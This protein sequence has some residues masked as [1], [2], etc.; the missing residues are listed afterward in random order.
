[1]HQCYTK[2]WAIS[3]NFFNAGVEA[4]CFDAGIEAVCFDRGRLQRAMLTCLPPVP[5]GPD[6]A[7][8]GD[9]R[10]EHSIIVGKLIK[11]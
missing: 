8:M 3:V 1:M 5:F 10:C 7:G 9:A 4:V 2:I 11:I 6:G